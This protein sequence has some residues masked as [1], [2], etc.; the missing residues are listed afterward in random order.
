MEDDGGMLE[1]SRRDEVV[2]VRQCFVVMRFSPD[3]EHH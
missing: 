1:N 2:T 3:P